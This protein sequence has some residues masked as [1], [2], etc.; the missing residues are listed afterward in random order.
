MKL[1]LSSFFLLLCCT[2]HS[3][4]S[5]NTI[6]PGVLEQLIG[7]DSIL[8]NKIKAQKN[9]K[10]IGNLA[11]EDIHFIAA[12]TKKYNLEQVDLS[13]TVFREIG[14]GLFEKCD[15][16]KSIVLPNTV[17]TIAK[18]AFKD[19]SSLSDINLPKN[20]TSIGSEAF[21][22]CTNLKRLII[23][24]NLSW[25][26]TNAFFGCTITSTKIKGKNKDFFVEDNHLYSKNRS[27]IY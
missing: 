9:I 21:Y 27:K 4:V 22:N 12:I 11:K 7:N 19:C 3:Q 15:S 16:L 20:L 17:K 26:G 24:K 14:F 10:V 2:L 1:L 8:C 25:I 23:F 18:N 13:K 5:I 6:E